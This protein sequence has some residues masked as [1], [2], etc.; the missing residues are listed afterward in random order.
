[1]NLVEILA[2]EL[3]DKHLTDFERIRY[4][5]IRCCEIF[6]FDHRWNYYTYYDEGMIKRIEN[7][8]FDIRNIDST[9]V[10]C[11]SFTFSILISLVR[12]FTHS[13]IRLNKGAHSFAELYEG[14]SKWILDATQ[15]DFPRVK[16]HLK[17]NGM[18][19]DGGIEDLTDMDASLGYTYLTSSY[20]RNQVQGSFTEQMTS[21]STILANSK[22]KYQFT[23]TLFL[24][25]YLS[26]MIPQDGRVLMDGN[27]KLY[28]LIKFPMFDDQEYVIKLNTGSY[29]L[30][31]CK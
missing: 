16:M 6:S 4:I 11:H 25:N 12:E 28:R 30:T 17:P 24:Y 22:C 9:L 7:K 31:K 20:Y 19:L 18:F 3:K 1:M 8:R 14:N 10:V 15:G 29:Q 5:Y 13:R 26:H 23:D 2:E 21:I 27:N